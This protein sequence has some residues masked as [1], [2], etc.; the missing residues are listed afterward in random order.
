VNDE[1]VNEVDWSIDRENV[2]V[3]IGEM[4]SGNAW[5]G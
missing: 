4:Y 2:I 1:V 3:I 5:Q